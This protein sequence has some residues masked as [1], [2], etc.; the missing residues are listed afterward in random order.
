MRTPATAAREAVEGRDETLYH[1]CH[2]RIC[3]SQPSF[4]Y[5][6]WIAC[7]NKDAEI[8]TFIE[9]INSMSPEERRLYDIQD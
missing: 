1:A 4:L 8:V 5:D 9:V 2:E 6:Q 3:E 7:M